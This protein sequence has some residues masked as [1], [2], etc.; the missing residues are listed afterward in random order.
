MLRVLLPI[1]VGVIIAERVTFPLWS[2]SLGFVLSVGV[3]AWLRSRSVANIYL[4]VAFALLGVMAVELRRGQSVESLQKLSERNYEVEVAIDRITNHRADKVLCDG[5]VVAYR[6]GREK[7]VMQRANFEVRVVA[8]SSVGLQIGSRVV[9]NSRLRLF[10]HNSENRYE[11]YMARRGVV[12]QLG[13]R[14]SDVMY[15]SLKGKGVVR[16][17]HAKALQRLYC[18]SLTPQS[19]A[20]V[21]AMTIGERGSVD[22]SLREEYA[23]SGSAHLLAVSGLHVG[24]VF[25]VINILLLAFALLRHGQL[26][27]V[28]PAVAAI[29]IYAA[30]AGASPSVV[31]AAVMFSILQLAFVV[32]AR[33]QALN[34]LA[35]TA[36]VMILCSASLLHDVGF[37]L[38]F[39]AVAGIVVWGVPLSRW[40]VV[41]RR[42]FERKLTYKSWRRDAVQSVVVVVWKAVVMSLTASVATMPLTAYMFGVVSWWSVVLGPLMIL[43]GMAVVSVAMAW[44][45]LPIGFLS[46]VASWLLETLTSTM[47]SIAAWCSQSGLLIQ[48]GY[49]SGWLCGGCYVAFV[50]FT[51]LLW[52]RDS[53]NRLP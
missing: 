39:A 26:W 10:A 40:S 15:H 6:M 37:L 21:E 53:A 36:S 49:I 17:L 3:A 18:L 28:V 7:S 41:T 52:S 35:F 42:P 2:V 23:R 31:R 47:N 13:L 29:W 34:S 20:V 14:Q 46:G 4:F 1:V 24:F 16:W 32:S 5:R 27:R 8:D 48:E 43:I 38:S 30:V 51:L 19:R 25:A 22:S 50:L 12:G 9:A 11:A 33:T 45:L 44:I